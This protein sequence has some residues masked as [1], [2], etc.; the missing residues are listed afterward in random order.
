MRIP[1]V[2]VAILAALTLAT[3]GLLLAVRAGDAQMNHGSFTAL[4]DAL[5]AEDAVGVQAHLAENFTLT[6]SGGTTLSGTEAVTTIMLLDTPINVVSVTP[7]GM[8]RG[9]AVVEFGGVPP[10]YTLTYTGARDGKFASI[11]IDLPTTPDN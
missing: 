8:S 5:N 2:L 1:R 9:S 11:V 7:G 6:M 10:Q 3:C 4:I